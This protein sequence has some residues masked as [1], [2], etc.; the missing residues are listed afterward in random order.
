ME[1]EGAKK[2]IAK[3][4]AD[5]ESLIGSFEHSTQDI[6]NDQEILLLTEVYREIALLDKR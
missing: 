6:C 3:K 4:I 5:R 2:I 1:N